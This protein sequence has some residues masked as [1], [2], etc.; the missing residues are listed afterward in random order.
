VPAACGAREEYD[1]L[2]VSLD[3]YNPAT[4]CSSK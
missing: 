2:K 1:C 4:P 3:G